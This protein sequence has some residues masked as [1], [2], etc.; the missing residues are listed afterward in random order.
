MIEPKLQ[1]K[2]NIGHSFPTFFFV[3]LIHSF[4]ESRL[5]VNMADIIDFDSFWLFD[6]CFIWEKNVKKPE[7]VKQS[8]RT[9]AMFT[10]HNL[11]KEVDFVGKC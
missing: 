1:V 10:L 7:Y 4:T 5:A 2:L 9:Q 8:Y 11:I 3:L 6:S